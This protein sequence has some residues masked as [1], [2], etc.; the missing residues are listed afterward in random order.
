MT[1]TTGRGIA[2]TGPKL[3]F[4][5][6][7]N[8]C[9]AYSGAITMASANTEYAALEFTSGSDYII[10]DVDFRNVTINTNNNTVAKWYLNDKLVFQAESES[11]ETAT[12]GLKGVIIIPPLT[13]FKMTVQA[14]GS[15]IITLGTFTGRVV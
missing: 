5:E 10:G 6:D 13:K 8:H 1:T 12:P 4:T 3:I 7:G 15:G 9:Y 11:S 14:D 2:V